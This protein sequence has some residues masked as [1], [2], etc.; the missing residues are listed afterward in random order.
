MDYRVLGPLEVRDRDR[1]VSLGGPRRRA[2]LAVL[3]I[4]AND[5]VSTDQLADLVWNEDPPP[6]AANVVQGHVSDLRKTLGRDVIA[7]RGR[8]YELV[9]E[10]RAVQHAGNFSRK[11]FVKEAQD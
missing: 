1:V 6:A 4:R 9:V 2:L 7:T 5:V 8:G 3:I 11:I 10:A